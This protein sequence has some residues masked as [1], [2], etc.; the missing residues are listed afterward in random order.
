[1]ILD[2]LEEIKNIKINRK[3]MEEYSFT[4][5]IALSALAVIA[6][7]KGHVLGYFFMLLGLVFILFG[8]IQPLFL[9]QVYIIWMSF[10]L[11]L[12]KIMT[13]IILTVSYYLICVP[14]SLILKITKQRSQIAPQNTYWVAKS[15]ESKGALSY[16]KQY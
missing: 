2:I 5:F 9:K 6:L 4:M 14:I 11:L 1:M 13:T 15:N 16:E 10:S 3:K 7:I 12:G 8:A